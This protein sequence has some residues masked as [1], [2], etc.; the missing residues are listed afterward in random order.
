MNQS[1]TFGDAPQLIEVVDDAVCAVPVLGTDGATNWYRVQIIS[2]NPET[3]TCLVK[4]LDYG[5]YVSVS[6]HDLRQIRADFMTVPFQAIQVML[7]NIKP[8]G[9]KPDSFHPT[10]TRRS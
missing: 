10:L 7:G 8:V 2:H 5:G 3:E 4:Y 6:T 1:Y 9:K